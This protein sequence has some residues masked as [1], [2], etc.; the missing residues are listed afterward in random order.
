MC[1]LRVGVGVSA[2]FICVC[3]VSPGKR[4]DVL[5]S[6]DGQSCVEL[7]GRQQHDIHSVCVRVCVCVCVCGPCVCVVCVC[8]ITPCLCNVTAQVSTG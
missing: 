2:D 3:A 4:M 8:V 7:S 1:T 5:V 6:P